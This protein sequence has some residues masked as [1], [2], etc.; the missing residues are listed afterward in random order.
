MD[1]VKSIRYASFKDIKD[2]KR[3]VPNVSDRYYTY[4]QPI[5]M[6]YHLGTLNLNWKYNFLVNILNKNYNA[7]KEIVWEDLL[8]SYPGQTLR[9]LAMT[10][11]IAEHSVNLSF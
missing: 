1:T 3:S 7:R 9:S 10:V 5:L 4:L 6:N 8:S 11:E 2:L